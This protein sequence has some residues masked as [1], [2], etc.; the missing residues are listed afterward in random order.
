MYFVIVGIVLDKVRRITIKKY[1]SNAREICFK[2]NLCFLCLLNDIIFFG[3][4][5]LKCA[6]SETIISPVIPPIIEG[7]SGPMYFAV[8]K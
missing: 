2:G 1:G 3:V 6:A 5:N 4:R 8:R 7:S